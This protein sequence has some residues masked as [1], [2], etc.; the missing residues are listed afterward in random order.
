M[1]FDSVVPY[2]KTRFLV[3]AGIAERKTAA[4]YLSALEK[5]GLLKRHKIGKENLFLNVPLYA[6]LSK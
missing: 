4:E 6:L 1:T 5:M 3:E 2:F